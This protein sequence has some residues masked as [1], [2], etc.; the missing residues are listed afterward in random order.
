MSRWLPETVVLH[1]GGNFP[2]EPARAGSTAALLADV[3]RQLDALAF[4]KSTRLSCVVGGEA[5]RHAVV[6]WIDELSSTVQR[7]GLAEQTYFETFGEVA[8]GWTVCLHSTGYG[9]GSLACAIE[10]AL[11]EGLE[12]TARLRGLNLVS[13]QPGLMHAFNHARRELAQGLFWF[14]LVE[15]RSVTLLLMSSSEPLQV[16]RLPVP[17]MGL[18]RLLDREWFALGLEGPRCPVFVA[19]S[20]GMAPATAADE[21]PPAFMAPWTIT[22]LP[23]APVAASAWVRPSAAPEQVGA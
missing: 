20:A 12:S 9:T 4:R 11:F 14:V 6:P 15:S 2:A 5:V 18:P 7:Q 16:K 23:S 1:L 21:L 3:E 22:A 19:R 8:R 10:T 17:A 13:V